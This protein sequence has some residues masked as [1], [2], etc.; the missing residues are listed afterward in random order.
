MRGR[1]IA[2]MNRLMNLLFVSPRQCWP[3]ASGAKLREY[4]LAR[5]LGSRARLHYVFFSAP[6]GKPPTQ[7]DLPFCAEITELPPARSYTPGKI[8][9]GMLGQ[10]PISVLNYT[11]PEMT[12]A[13]TRIASSAKFD[14]IHLDS[15]H[16]AA[17]EPVLRRLQSDAR[18]VYDWHNIESDIMRQY[19][20]RSTSPA[21]KLYS[22]LT[23]PKLTALEHRILHSAFGHLVCSAR[24]REQLRAIA[25]G[26]RIEV[27]ENGVDT[28]RF[29]SPRKDL[30]RYRIVYVGLMSYHANIEA[31]VWFTREIWPSIRRKFPQWT[32]TLVGA[33][34]APPVLDLAREA[35][36]EVTGTVPDV[37]PYYDQAIAA[38]VPLRTGGGT[39]L[40]ILEAMAAGVPVVSTALGAEGLEISPG[41]NILL[42]PGDGSGLADQWIA[43][44]E[45]AAADGPLRSTLISEGRRLVG[46]RYDWEAIG[47]KTFD[48][49]RR[50]VDPSA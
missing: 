20:A 40:K 3:A 29:A 11:S 33:D 17:Y 18:I 47:R 14:V 22:A 21:R 24:E 42:A 27:I 39:R 37:A 23:T 1:E 19:T 6:H 46:D 41:V 12:A 43:S 7:A 38:V 4:H 9:R 44:L 26:A 50:W 36:V 13:L 49:Y 45:S 34:P 28:S 15:I 25:P 31:A 16:L 48:L 5:A 35:G 32:L 2:M 10:W 30:P 8:V